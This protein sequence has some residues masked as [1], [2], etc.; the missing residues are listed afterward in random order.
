MTAELYVHK[1]IFVNITFNTFHFSDKQHMLQID[2][3][4]ARLQFSVNII[5]NN[6][7]YLYCGT[8]LPWSMFI[9]SN[10]AMVLIPAKSL[11]YVE[12]FNAR[13]FFIDLVIV[14]FTT[15]LLYPSLQMASLFKT[16]IRKE[17]RLGSIV[18]FI[19]SDAFISPIL[20]V[21]KP[22]WNKIIQKA[23]RRGTWFNTWMNISM[24]VL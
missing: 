5:D 17:A 14:K 8:R 11:E 24:H 13:K 2:D 19:V 15:N 4:C 23:S 1:L 21:F 6:N 3:Y 22:L 20:S 9:D 12:A 18:V 7:S 10:M 16:N